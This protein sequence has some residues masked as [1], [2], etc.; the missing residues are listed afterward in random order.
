M[1][2]TS[3]PDVF[4][5]TLTDG[6]STTTTTLTIDVVVNHLGYIQEGKTLTVANTASLVSGTSTGSHTGAV[7]YTHLTLP[8]TG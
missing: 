8:T 4:T 5:Y 6:A 3:G 7:S 1:D 2:V